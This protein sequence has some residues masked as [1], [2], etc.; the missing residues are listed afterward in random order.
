M[1]FVEITGGLGNQMFQYV[2]SKYLEQKTGQ[3]SALYINFYDYV[4]DDPVLSQ[5]K[6]ELGKFHT[7]FISINGSVNYR[8]LI[9]EPSYNDA[10]NDI[11]L[12]F[13]KGYWQDKKYFEVVSE[14]I[15]KEFIPKDEF[16][17]DYVHKKAEEIKGRDSISIHVRRTDFLNAQNA[18][19]FCC[20]SPEYYEK[21]LNILSDE[22]GSD[23]KIY[24]FSDDP[25]YVRDNFSF[26]KNYDHEIMAVGDAYEDIYLMSLSKHHII[27]N[28]TFSWWGAALSANTDGMTIAPKNW[29]KNQ[30]SPNLYLKGWLLI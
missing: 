17:S 18:D 7:H 28:S 15:K 20:L 8:K 6:F 3:T 21:G 13:Y 22:C 25:D 10:D 29:Y 2:F 5:R 23:A 4:K 9:Y 26:I 27:A 30:P 24:V 16:L 1:N 11:I 19:T 12:D 14:E